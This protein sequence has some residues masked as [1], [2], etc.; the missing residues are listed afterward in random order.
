MSKGVGNLTAGERGEFADLAEAVAK[1][2]DRDAFIALFNYYAPR[3]IAYLKRLGNSAEVSEE[4]CQEAMLVV[5]SKSASFD[6]RRSAFSTWLYRIARNKHIDRL[7]RLER[8]NGEP[9]DPTFMPEAP[10][11]PDDAVAGRA[12]EQRLRKALTDL[13]VEQAELVHLSFYEG[14]SHR[15]IADQLALPLGTVKS[16]LRLAVGRLKN[17]LSHER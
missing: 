1:N 16:R 13:P 15:E 8:S 7:R 14:K 2:R 4:L 6:H 3:L 10:I 5:W 12:S 11:Q 9:F 17:S